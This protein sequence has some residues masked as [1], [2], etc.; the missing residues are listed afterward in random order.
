MRISF[1]IGDFFLTVSPKD[2]TLNIIEQLISYWPRLLLAYSFNTRFFLLV[3]L[4]ADRKNSCGKFQSNV[5][6][7]LFLFEIF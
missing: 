2:C 1:I 3:S 7:D 5:V 6:N 4:I